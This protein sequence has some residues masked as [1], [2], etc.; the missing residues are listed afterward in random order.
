MRVKEKISGTTSSIKDQIGYLKKDSIYF[1]KILNSKN[2]VFLK[3]DATAILVRKKGNEQEFFK[4]F[5]NIT[6]EGYKM[7]L[8]EEITDPVPGIKVN[9]GY[10]YFFQ[11]K[12]FIN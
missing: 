7:M 8:S 3:T 5:D 1:K 12:K 9:L 11:N 10:V 4:E 6:K 2:I